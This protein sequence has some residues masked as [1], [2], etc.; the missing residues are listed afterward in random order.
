MGI[1]IFENLDLWGSVALVFAV[2]LCIPSVVFAVLKSESMIY[3]FI[4]SS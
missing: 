2:S 4:L 1:S 3:L